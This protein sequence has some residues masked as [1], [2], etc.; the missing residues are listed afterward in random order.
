MLYTT[1]PNNYKYTTEHLEIHI[2]GGMKTTK[3][4]TLRITLSIQK[5]KS[6][7]ILR[8]SIDLYNDN[9]TEN[10]R[11]VGDRHDHRQAHLAGTDQGTGKPSLPIVGAAN[12][13]TDHKEDDRQ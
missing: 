12:G 4:E 13:S 10:R 8:H 11:K 9:Q 6:H 2:L 5:P 7:N 3:L 1:D